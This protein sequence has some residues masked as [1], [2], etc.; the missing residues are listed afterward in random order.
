MS[1]HQ[2]IQDILSILESDSENKSVQIEKLKQFPNKTKNKA[3]GRECVELLYEAT[4][5]LKG[6]FGIKVKKSYWLNNIKYQLL[7]SIHLLPTRYELVVSRLF[8]LYLN[9]CETLSQPM[10]DFICKRSAYF[11]AKSTV[12]TIQECFFGIAINNKTEDDKKVREDAYNTVTS[13]MKFTYAKMQDFRQNKPIQC[14][15]FEYLSLK[16]AFNAQDFNWTMRARRLIIEGLALDWNLLAIKNLL[17]ILDAR[18]EKGTD[19]W[20]KYAVKILHQTQ[21]GKK[22]SES[23]ITKDFFILKIDQE[24]AIHVHVADCNKQLLEQEIKAGVSEDEL[25]KFK[26]MFK[27]FDKNQIGHLH[28]DSFKS[29]LRALGYENKWFPMAKEGEDEPEFESILDAVDPKREDKITLQ[30]NLFYKGQY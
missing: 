6:N 15:D 23:M 9:H 1:E 24:L 27:Q 7:Q 17:L 19:L 8:L 26:E 13:I 28:Q 14:M 12:W 5:A 4:F 25:K 22:K 10:V 20:L 21:H 16:F 11:D 3:K 2:V 29:C 18:Q 30:V